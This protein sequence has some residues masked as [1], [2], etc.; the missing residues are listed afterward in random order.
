MSVD[1][2][3]AQAIIIP[4]RSRAVRGTGG[5]VYLAR[6]PSRKAAQHAR[7]R[8]RWL[9][10]RAQLAAPVEQIVQEVNV[11]LRGWAGYFRYGNS[12]REFDKIRS[13]AVMRV[14][15]FLAKRHQRG[16]R[17]QSVSWQQ[18]RAAWLEALG[19]ADLG[20]YLQRRYLE[21]GWSIKRMRAELGVGRSWL[22][23]QMAR[24]G[25]W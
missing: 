22:V 8:I 13:Y 7:D 1:G 2:S 12:A 5:L 19:F 10:M 24:L 25:L 11:F 20:G 23:A 16:R 9:T 14:A 21:Q 15:L 18:R 6:W 4:S 3:S 17:A